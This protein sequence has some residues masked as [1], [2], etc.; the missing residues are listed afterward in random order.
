[1]RLQSG[2]TLI[3]LL[4]GVALMG[5]LLALSVPAFD[6]VIEQTRASAVVNQMQTAI[7]LA[8]HEAVFR[9]RQVVICRTTDFRRC[10]YSG[11][12]SVGTMTFEDRNFDQNL[13]PGEALIGVQHAAD[14][15]GLHLVGSPRRPVIGFRPDGRSAGT[16]N[17]LRLCATSLETLRLLIINIGGRTR[18]A[19]GDRHTPR[20]GTV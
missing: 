10:T 12:W 7:S 8:R 17:T 19:H 20:C 16:N 15:Q 11:A 9:R 1:M 6:G 4:I 2:I 13:S 5:T 18:V 3:E 14:F